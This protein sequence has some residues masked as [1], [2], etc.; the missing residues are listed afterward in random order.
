MQT[1]EDIEDIKEEQQQ[2]SEF[3]LPELLPDSEEPLLLEENSE[4]ELLLNADS[5]DTPAQ[6]ETASDN[7]LLS[8][9]AILEEDMSDSLLLQ[10][11][12]PEPLE[13]TQDLAEIKPDEEADALKLEEDEN[14]LEN[15]VP[16]L[17]LESEAEDEKKLLRKLWQKRNLLKILLIM[18][19]IYSFL[20][21][22]KDNDLSS[23]DEILT[24]NEEVTLDNI[25]PDGDLPELSADEGLILEDNIAPVESEPTP[26]EKN[27]QKQTEELSLNVEQEEDT[28]SPL[29][30][31]ELDTLEALDEPL[32]LQDESSDDNQHDITGEEGINF[33]IDNN[34]END[35]LSSY[36]PQEP[37]ELNYDDTDTDESLH[38]SSDYDFDKEINKENESQSDTEEDAY[39]KAFDVVEKQP[40]TENPEIQSLLD[41]DLMALL[42]DNDDLEATNNTNLSIENNYADTVY[43]QNDEEVQ[44][45]QSNDE[46]EEH[47]DET[48]NSLFENNENPQPQNGENQTFELAQEPVSAKNC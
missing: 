5:E 42:S 25:Q 43:Q 48:I 37:I 34:A 10:D 30:L 1:E 24:E 16:E 4:E 29:E 12:E 36:A 23:P 46:S 26:E 21:T 45:N 33:N 19:I 32:E 31:E 14:L 39:H 18:M 9:D 6:E 47:S 15:N 7:L 3:D 13:E 35:N 41:D 38:I 44:Q 2:E 17:N 8:D 20:L 22:K 28:I 40:E 27:E 11:T